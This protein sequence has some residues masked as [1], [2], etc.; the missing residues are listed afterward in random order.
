MNLIDRRKEKNACGDDEVM[1]GPKDLL[2]IM[3]Q[4]A[5]TSGTVNKNNVTVDD[6]VEECKT[7]FFAGKHTT[8]NLLTW[9]TILLAMHPQWQ[10]R[11][12]EELLSVCGARD[13]I[14]TKDH[15]ARLK[16]VSISFKH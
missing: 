4:E 10:V 7:F 5:S 1:K 3:I 11:A 13:V 9:T 12:R 15:L 6:M 2:G 8:S 16:T 14:P